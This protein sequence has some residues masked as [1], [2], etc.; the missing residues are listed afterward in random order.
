MKKEEQYAVIIGE[1]IVNEALDRGIEI[2]TSKLMKLLYFMQK[3]HLRKYGKPMFTDEVTATING[4]Y[5]QNIDNYFIKGRL[6]FDSRLEKSIILQDSHEDVSNF[7]LDKYGNLTPSELMKLSQE[8][9]LFK[10]VW[11][12]GKTSNMSIPFRVLANNIECMKVL[13]LS[14]DKKQV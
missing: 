14:K 6:G 1:V 11:E 7:V 12:N 2:N 13:K 9:V 8:D 4:P 10:T 3:L 5:I